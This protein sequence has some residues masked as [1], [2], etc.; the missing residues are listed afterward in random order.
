MRGSSPAWPISCQL[1]VPVGVADARYHAFRRSVLLSA[2]LLT[3]V[4]ALLLVML[5]WWLLGRRERAVAA[6]L[7]D[8]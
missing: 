8:L 1:S 7:R 3:V 2:A 6:E 4:A 5:W